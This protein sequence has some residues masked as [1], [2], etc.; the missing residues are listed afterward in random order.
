[1]KIFITGAT[2]FIGAKLAE[3]LKKNGHQIV[4]LVR[5]SS[6]TDLL[7]SIGAT[8]VTG[9]IL[10]AAS[11]I[12]AIDKERPEIV[13]HCAAYVATHE[14][15]KVFKANVDGTKNVFEASLGCGVKRVVYLSSVSVVSGNLIAPL[16]DD[17]AYKASNVYGES[18]IAA[19]KIAMEYRQKGLNIAILRPGMVFG[20]GE[21]HQLDNIL[22]RISKGI[23]PYPGIKELNDKLQ[24]VYIDNL[25][26]IMEIAMEKVSALS[27]TFLV[28]DKEIITIREFL[29]ISMKELGMGRM[30]IIPGWLIKPAL[31]IPVLREKF[32]RMFKD[33]L[34]DISRVEKILGYRPVISTQ[35]ALRLTV[36]KWKEKHS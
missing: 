28:A 19:E 27:G 15:E 7:K 17:L 33:R 18:K 23:V 4:C 29:E 10:D 31:F 25:I 3:R 21:P 22:K 30:I 2:G 16:T 6:K 32:G 5:T 14:P 35:D 9:D 20:P 13:F 24:L 12:S 11:V 36:K 34:Y 1:M 26:D 8:L